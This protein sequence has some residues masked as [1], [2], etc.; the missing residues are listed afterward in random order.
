MGN[1]FY[2]VITVLIW[3]STFLAI[4]FQLG[5]VPP[6]LSIAYRFFAGCHNPFLVQRS[7]GIASKVRPG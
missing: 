1:G 3:G 6:E 4:K 2:Y 7:A 5:V